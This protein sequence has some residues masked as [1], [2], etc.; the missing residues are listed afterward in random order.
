[1][2]DATSRGFTLIEL[3]VVLVIVG[4]LM[5]SAPGALHRVLPTLEIK[6]AAREMSAA[7][8]EARSRS[9]RD[10]SE[11][12]LEINTEDRTYRVEGTEDVR[13]YSDDFAV[14]LVAAA[15]EQVD[16]AV[17]RIRFYPDGT[18]TGGRLTLSRGDRTYHVV[19]DW[20]TGHVRL[21]E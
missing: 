3:L 6:A 13:S 7:L 4:V 5:A 20:L 8:R 14:T 17:G 9:L 16:E 15:S 12:A 10:N 1:M 2:K 21:F 19:V 11:T 18:S